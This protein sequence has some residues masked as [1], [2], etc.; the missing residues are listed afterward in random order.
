MTIFGC[1]FSTIATFATAAA[2]ALLSD[3]LLGA[4]RQQQT[5]TEGKIGAAL[6]GAAATLQG[7]GEALIGGGGEVLGLTLDATG[8]G[9][10]LGVPINVVSTAVVAHGIAT[11]IEGG[12][13]LIQDAKQSSMEPKA[14]ESGGPGAGK[15]ISDKTKAQALEENKAANGGQ[16]KCVYCKEPV[17]EG[18]SNKINFDHSQAKSQNGTNGLNNVNVTCEYCNKSKGTGK[19]PKNPKKKVTQN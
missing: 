6:G 12:G 8:V 4:G 1:D 15:D 3:N 18:T 19:A 7:T 5:T 9:A 11:G 14:G 17:G 13:H 2:N 10:L 16:A